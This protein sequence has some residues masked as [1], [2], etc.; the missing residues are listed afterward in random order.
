VRR[1]RVELETE[2]AFGVGLGAAGFFHAL[3]ELEHD[4]IVSGGWLAGGGIFHGPGE[5]LGGGEGGEE[6]NGY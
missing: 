2:L 3:T 4:H 6:E 1:L 5:G